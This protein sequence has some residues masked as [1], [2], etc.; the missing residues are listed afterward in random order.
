LAHGI[1]YLLPL[2]GK[3]LSTAEV[4]ALQGSRNAA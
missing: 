4:R 2:G 3:P 1:E